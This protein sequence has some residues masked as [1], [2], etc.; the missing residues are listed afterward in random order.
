MPL[1][2]LGQCGHRAVL[3]KSRLRVLP[4]VQHQCDQ[5]LTQL[6]DVPLQ[7]PV[8]RIPCAG[9]PGAGVGDLVPSGTGLLPQYLE[10]VR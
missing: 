8:Q 7:T 1:Q 9:E 10:I 3:L 6:V 4:Q 5:L 2:H